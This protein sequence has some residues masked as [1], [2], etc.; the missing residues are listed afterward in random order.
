MKK[1]L[2]IIFIDINNINLK[3]N[4]DNPQNEIVEKKD[5][6]LLSK[7]I[8]SHFIDNNIL[9]DLEKKEN[10]FFLQYSFIFKTGNNTSCGCKFFYF[11]KVYNEKFNI[12]KPLFIFCDIGDSKTL[13]LLKEFIEYIKKSDSKD[14]KISILGIKKSKNVNNLKKEV[15]I[16]LFNDEELDFKYNE[17][18]LSE[19]FNENEE[20]DEEIFE[21]I[22]KTIEVEIITLHNCEEVNHIV[23]EKMDEEARQNSSK[24]NIF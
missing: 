22:D 21:E 16:K 1:D 2:E 24:C 13:T 7:K 11:N 20:E 23:G 14:V 18:D 8:I 9:I 12:D 10:E 15:I 19:N 17:F 4:N 6:E 5:E 3:L